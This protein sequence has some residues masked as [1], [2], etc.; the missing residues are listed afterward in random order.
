MGMLYE[1]GPEELRSICPPQEPAQNDARS[2]HAE[3]ERE[4]TRCAKHVVR[5]LGSLRGQG[6]R[7]GAR[8]EILQEL[9]LAAFDAGY[10]AGHKAATK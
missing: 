7:V 5:A 1:Y 10:V 3:A 6:D 8:L 2:I 9:Y 4:A